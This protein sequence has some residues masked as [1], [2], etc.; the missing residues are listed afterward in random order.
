M[1]AE[2]PAAIRSGY[3]PELGGVLRSG[4]ARSGYEPEL[5]GMLRQKAVYVDEIT[6]IGC[7]HCAY[8]ARGTFYLE[9]EY[10]RSRVI[11]QDG[12]DEDRIQ[13]AI[14][15]CPVDC[16]HW[17]GYT[18]LPALEEARRF[19]QIPDIGLPP[20]AHKLRPRR[21][22]SRKPRVQKAEGR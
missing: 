12:D 8:V 9:S 16:I 6:C 19:Q 4:Q 3:E 21:P 22:V 11:N 15:C 1:S 10:G 20:T 14:D 5:G 2:E 7:G 18:E 17:V 13:E